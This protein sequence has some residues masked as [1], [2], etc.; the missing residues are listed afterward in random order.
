[1]QRKGLQGTQWSIEPTRDL[2]LEL[3][4]LQRRLI[5][6]KEVMTSKWAARIDD[7]CHLATPCAHVVEVEVKANDLEVELA[8]TSRGRRSSGT[9]KERPPKSVHNPLTI[10]EAHGLS[11]VVDKALVQGYDFSFRVC[12]LIIWGHFPKVRGATEP[13]ISCNAMPEEIVLV[14]EH[15]RER[16]RK[17]FLR[18]L[19]KI[20]KLSLLR[21]HSTKPRCPLP[22][23]TTWLG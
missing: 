10:R 18:P 15:R 2:W 22:K 7:A 3:A 6:A 14:V 9:I 8:H 5:D 16:L 23:I 1:M 11:R 12:E 4:L 21:S 19:P 20:T 17:A 13:L